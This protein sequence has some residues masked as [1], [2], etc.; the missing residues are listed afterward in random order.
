MCG[1][2]EGQQFPKLR[3]V[4]HAPEQCDPLQARRIL[5]L[6]AP[7]PPAA[8]LSHVSSSAFPHPAAQHLVCHFC[9]FHN[10]SL[11][12]THLHTQ[13]R[14][15]PPPP[16]RA[17]RLFPCTPKVTTYNVRR[18]LLVQHTGLAAALFL[19]LTLSSLLTLPCFPHQLQ[20][21]HL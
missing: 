13:H 17:V 12:H 6:T 8:G 1:L 20:G 14:D 2:L 21:C 5:P 15:P 3:P 18:F 10:L 9:K 7:Q 11:S 4:C 16:R 19:T